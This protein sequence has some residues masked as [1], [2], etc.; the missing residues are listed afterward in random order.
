MEHIEEGRV[1]DFS[2]Q[3]GGW[4]VG[5]GANFPD[6]TLRRM[7]EGAW[8]HTV[9]VKWMAHQPG[10]PNGGD[11][12]VSAGRTLSLLVSDA[13]DFRIEFS[14]QP[15]FAELLKVSRLRGQGDFVIWGGGLHHRWFAAAAST[16]LTVRWVPLESGTRPGGSGPN[17]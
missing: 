10:D 14:R 17:R 11:K 4:F 5:F 12:P 8:A 16:I 6:P 7:A 3:G 1:Q 15:D 9:G 2:P 13:G